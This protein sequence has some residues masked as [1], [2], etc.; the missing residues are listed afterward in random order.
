M[1]EKKERIDQ[2]FQTK[3]ENLN[4]QLLESKIN[5]AESELRDKDWH[6]RSDNRIKC[7]V[8]EAQIEALQTI[9]PMIDE[10]FHSPRQSMA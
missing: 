9:E 10:I 2:L 8:I 1:Q 4:S 7:K 3:I 6:S 5:L